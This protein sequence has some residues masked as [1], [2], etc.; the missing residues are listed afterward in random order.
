MLLGLAGENGNLLTIAD[1]FAKEEFSSMDLFAFDAVCEF[2]Y[3]INGL[4]ACSLST[5]GF[6]VDMVPPS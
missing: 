1:V 6:M 4:Y 3:C 5:Q 2:I